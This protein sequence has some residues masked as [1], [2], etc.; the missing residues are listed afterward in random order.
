[1]AHYKFRKPWAPKIVGQ[2]SEMTTGHLGIPEIDVGQVIGNSQ[3][4]DV[5]TSHP[6][7]QAKDSCQIVGSG[8]ANSLA[9]QNDYAGKN[10]DK[11]PVDALQ[12]VGYV[13]RILHRQQ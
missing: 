6:T 1:M 8:L 4:T 11:S 10:F 3:S 13:F 12:V 7:R 9:K 2:T 5:S